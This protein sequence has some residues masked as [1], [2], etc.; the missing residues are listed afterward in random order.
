MK[1]YLTTIGE[2]TTEICREQ[3]ERFGFEVIILNKQKCWL[4]KYKDFVRMALAD[5]DRVGEDCCIRCDADVIVNKQIL[6]LGKEP[7]DYWFCHGWVYDFY[8]NDLHGAGPV[9]YRREALEIIAAKIDSL[10][11]YRPETTASRWPEINE[12]YF[13]SQLIVGMHGFFQAGRA[14]YEAKKNKIERGQIAQYDF[15][16]AQK[17]RNL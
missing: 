1:V 16:L 2:K 13:V 6:N 9:F 12:K 17:L 10:I 3:F 8:K 4:E 14:F 15:D 7:G 11:N 5:M